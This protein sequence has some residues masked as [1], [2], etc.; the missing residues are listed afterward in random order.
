MVTIQDPTRA[1]SA[2]H[3][4]ARPPQTDDRDLDRGTA[5]P[6]RVPQPAREYAALKR[7]VAQRGLLDKQPAYYTRRIAINLGLLALSS[8][9]LLGVDSFA[10]QLL[11]A[12][13]MAFALVQIAFV[14][15]NSGHRQVGTRPWHDVA[16]TQT[17]FGLLLGTSASWWVEKHNDH[18]GHPNV[19]DLD[20]DID[21]PMMAFSAEQARRKEGLARLVVAY[22]A[23]LYPIMIT[24][25]TLEM[26]WISIKKILSGTVKHPW[27]EAALMAAFFVWY[28][29]LLAIALDGWQILAFAALHHALIGI[30]LASVF[31]V[32][33]KGMPVLER[34]TDMDFLRLQ[35]VTA[36]NVRSERHTDFFYGGL[37]YQV[38]HHLFPT[39]PQNKLRE[40]RTIVMEFCQTH[41][42]PYYETG[43]LRSQWEILSHLHTVGAA[44]RRELGGLRADRRA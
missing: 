7:T 13:L 35:V 30:Y 21:F 20:P 32:N 24:F 31:A 44:L 18:H 4:P 6:M 43:F 37:N 5:T 38:E 29:G 15:H 28:F 8:L 25:I 10:V 2:H 22:Q 40:A 16:I 3:P 9:I 42:I 11:N 17:V 39:M 12:F 23:L 36:R 27:L 14:G 41:Q 33:H 34:D 1:P 26:R 19:D